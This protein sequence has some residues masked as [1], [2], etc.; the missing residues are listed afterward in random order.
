[1]TYALPS[2]Y[3][4]RAGWIQSNPLIGILTFPRETEGGETGDRN[5]RSGTKRLNVRLP[6][7]SAA[8]TPYFEYSPGWLE[9]GFALGGDLPLI[10]GRQKPLPGMR[11]FGFL[12]D[13]QPHPDAEVLFAP[14]PGEEMPAGYNPRM[15]KLECGAVSMPSSAIA[16]GGILFY[17]IDV[18]P[19]PSQPVVHLNDFRDL[20]F[21]WHAFERG[22]SSVSETALLRAAALSPDERL[23]FS[24]LANSRPCSIT[25]TSLND[26]YN[27]PFWRGFALKMARLA[28]IDT[29]DFRLENHLG[30]PY[31]N[32]ARCDRTPLKRTPRGEKSPDRPV[33]IHM[34]SA[35]TLCLRRHPRTDRV[36]PVSYLGIADI[37]NREGAEPGADLP[38]LWDRLVYTLLTNRAG[39][40]PNRWQFV[41]EELGWRLAPAHLLEWM[42]A[43]YGSRTQGI[44]ADGR[45]QLV[46][47]EDA[48]ALCGYFALKTPDAKMRLMAIR[49]ALRDWE[50]MA[51]E[52]GANPNDISMMA[53]LFD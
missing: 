4:V 20:V 8:D 39:D 11:T 19:Q 42:P 28:G 33:L 40:R 34:A 14:Q 37:L 30:E 31:L 1:M 12:K 3:E 9:T 24:L 52:E 18:P 7:S 50:G 25:L 38:R 41:R 44:T 17:G 2:H 21:G 51:L 26:P 45:R 5:S 48:V 49:R 35:S 36:A 27:V 22:K 43:G 47:A 29:V 53:T 23:S 13:R 15:S 32:T 16:Y 10:S 46:E 6:S